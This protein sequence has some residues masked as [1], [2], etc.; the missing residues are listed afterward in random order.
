M[1]LYEFSCSTCGKRFEKRLLLSTEQTDVHCP[2]GHRKVHRIY[3]ATPV[4]FKGSGFYVT[5]H[6]ASPAGDANKS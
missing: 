1:P 3:A 2:S 5:D 6:P 4:M